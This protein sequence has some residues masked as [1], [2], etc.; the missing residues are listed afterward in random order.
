MLIELDPIDK[1]I[2]SFSGLIAESGDKKLK[3]FRS[4]GR[5]RAER[6]SRYVLS[7]APKRIVF[8]AES[9]TDAITKANKKLNT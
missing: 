4:Q 6:K 2:S 9:D 1:V 5:R 3:L 7:G 8:T